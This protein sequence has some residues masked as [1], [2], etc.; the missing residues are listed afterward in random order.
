MEEEIVL[1]TALVIIL[2][3]MKCIF[4]AFIPL[5]NTGKWQFHHYMLQSKVKVDV[6]VLVQ[7]PFH[8]ACLA[9]SGK[10]KRNQP[11]QGNIM[12]TLLFSHLI[13]QS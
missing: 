6:V 13:P 5:S 7:R 4:L 3:N 8:T 11:K 12:K 9:G 10:S 2:L 1:H